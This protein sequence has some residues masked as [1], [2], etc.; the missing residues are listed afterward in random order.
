ME[1]TGEL[2]EPTEVAYPNPGDI[3]DTN[4]PAEL[5]EP[6]CA[7][8][9][10]CSNTRPLHKTTCH[11]DDEGAGGQSGAGG[12]GGASNATVAVSTT[13]SAGGG[14]DDE[15]SNEPPSSEV[16]CS[17]SLADP[18]PARSLPFWLIAMALFM[19]RHARGR[20]LSTPLD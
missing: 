13:S 7:S 9:T 14:F 15:P 12:Y 4:K 19:R 16:S 18:A 17:C 6:E 5:P 2:W 8:P 20:A 1:H 11:D 10:D 3:G